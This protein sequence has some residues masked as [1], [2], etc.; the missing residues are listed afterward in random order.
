[1]GVFPPSMGCLLPSM[2]FFGV[3]LE[4]PMPQQE[5]SCLHV[6]DFRHGKQGVAVVVSV[7]GTRYRCTRGRFYPGVAL[8]EKMR[9]FPE[10]P[11]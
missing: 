10:I 4:S 11:E 7:I 1:M 8:F 6:I 5:V 2:V 3:S 9:C